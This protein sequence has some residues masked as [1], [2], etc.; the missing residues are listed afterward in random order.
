[1]PKGMTMP[2]FDAAMF[3]AYGTLKYN[4]M[5]AAKNK[6]YV[7]FRP[8]KSEQLAHANRPDMLATEIIITYVA[9]KDPSTMVGNEEVKISPIIVFATPITPIP[10]VTLSVKLSH[11]CQN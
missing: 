7:F 1:M 6:E 10:A 8:K 2:G 5:P 4:G 9:A 11:S 3:A